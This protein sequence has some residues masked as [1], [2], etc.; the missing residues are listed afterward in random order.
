MVRRIVARI[1]ADPDRAGLEHAR[2]VCERWVARGNR[3]ARERQEILRR[4]WPEIRQILLDE[5]EE[6][7]RLRQ[8][9]HSAA[10]S[11]PRNEKDRE[12]VHALL[13]HRLTTTADIEI[14]CTS[15]TNRLPREFDDHCNH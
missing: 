4:P 7:Q 10:S 9:A 13:R 6:G 1:D 15:S 5:S 3:S 14:V 11:R 12:F 2:R 8:T